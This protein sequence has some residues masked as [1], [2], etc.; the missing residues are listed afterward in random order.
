MLI[1]I[2]HRQKGAICMKKVI[3][4]IILEGYVNKEGGF[5]NLIIDN[6]MLSCAIQKWVYFNRKDIVDEGGVP[7]KLRINAVITCE[8]IEE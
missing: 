1:Y 7:I 4:N 8:I 3:E 6:Y 2:K 5:E